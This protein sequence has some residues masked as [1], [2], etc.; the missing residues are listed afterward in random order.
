MN[1]TG[2]T[3]EQQGFG[4]SLRGLALA[5]CVG[6]ALFAGT[7][8]VWAVAT[9]LS[10]AVIAS[11]QFVVDGNVKK[12]QHATGGIVGELRVREGDRVEQ[13]QVVIR[14]DDTVTRAN[15]Q[16]V[17]KQLDELGVR[18]GRVEAER[19]G[20][21]AITFVADLTARRHEPELAELIEAEM[22]L[23]EARRAAR[24]GQKAQLSA[25]IAQL[26]DEI[27][28]LK[29]QQK[30][31][32]LQ[33]VLIEE[34]LTGIRWLYARNLVA[35]NRRTA[36]EREAASLEGQKGQLIAALAQAQGK[37]AETR[38]Q[39][40]QIDAALREEVMKELRE[41]QARSAELV[42]RRVAAE[43]QM[44]RVEIRSPSSGF[45]HQLAVHTVGGVITPA[46]PAMLIV[47]AEDA[48]QVEARI[49][50]PD[51]DQIALGQEARVKIHAF[52]QR[53]TPELAGKVTR[54][55]AD[56]SRDQQTGATFYTIRVSM[57]AAEFARL[58]QNRVSAGMQAE[59]FVK[60]ED[61]TPLE[62]IVKP[63]KDQIA[64]AFRE[65]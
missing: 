41:I 62:Y 50:P 36:L 27:A 32:D 42:E 45:V 17:V 2:A 25:R 26:G 63:L 37:I 30:A 52:N 34:E 6:L 19:A 13:D 54:I 53:T 64:K 60:T 51:I 7:V 5:G 28:G 11:G 18:R 22:S 48:L 29:A 40:I 33:A 39:I 8:G 47:P 12:V 59:V 58:G 24:D 35:L 9:T 38:L 43:D 16:V 65:R 1:E 4:R 23:F 46:E 21:D 10:G 31:R 55:S 44:K 61:R 3:L 14:L 15:L 49:N 20:K 56:T 57:P